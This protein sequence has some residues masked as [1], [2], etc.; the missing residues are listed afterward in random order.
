MTGPVSTLAVDIEGGGVTRAA[1]VATFSARGGR[2]IT[3]FRDASVD[4]APWM[5]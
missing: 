1:G 2:L 5:T 4:G 3:E